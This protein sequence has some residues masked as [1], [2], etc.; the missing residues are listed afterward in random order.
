[1]HHVHSRVFRDLRHHATFTQPSSRQPVTT[2]TTRSTARKHAHD[3]LTH[4]SHDAVAYRGHDK[5]P[6][7]HHF[8]SATP[9]RSLQCS[10]IKELF[11]RPSHWDIEPP[12]GTRDAGLSGLHQHP[13]VDEQKARPRQ[14]DTK[15]PVGSRDADPPGSR[16][17]WID[18][19]A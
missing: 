15:T 19:T 16:H 3:A 2:T 6:N 11:Q 18:D 10:Q 4:P 17:P 9:I 1:M 5:S 7:T 12:K 13:E 14:W 8:I